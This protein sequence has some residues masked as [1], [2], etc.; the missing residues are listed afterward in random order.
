M[1]TL[2][3]ISDTKGVETVLV[4]VV[5][6]AG[7]DHTLFPVGEQDVVV[8]TK[9]AGLGRVVDATVLDLLRH[10]GAAGGGVQIEAHVALLALEVGPDGCV[11]WSAAI[12]D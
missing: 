1:H 10:G 5:L 11:V 2:Q 12:G 4:D 7:G 8:E 9:G 3:T 6:D